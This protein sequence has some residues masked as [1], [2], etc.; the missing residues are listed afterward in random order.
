VPEE[1]TDTSLAG[2]ENAVRV[3]NLS[4]TFPNGVEALTDVSLTVRQGEFLVVI[5]L[6]GSGKSTLL[7]C[8]N[9]LVDP[10]EGRIWIF[11]EEITAAEGAELRRMRGQIGMIFQQFNLVKRHTVLSNVLSGSL[12]RSSLLPS[13]FLNFSEATK[14]DGF[15][16]LERVGLNGREA[17]RADALSGGQQQRVAIAR[18]LMQRPQLILADEPVASLDPALRHSVMRHI[19]ALNREEG[20]TVVCTLHDVDLIRRYA[21]RL[22]ALRDGKLVFDGD[23]T[24]FGAATFRRIYGEEAEPM[25][26]T[27]A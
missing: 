8:I 24:K 7:R 5:G 22:M 21:T 3:E 23:P 25:E 11:D 4:K 9:R 19:E 6:S 18:A 10:S 12:G 15:A 27:G 26:G 13:L 1:R 16:C 20:M 2:S 17:S 14:A